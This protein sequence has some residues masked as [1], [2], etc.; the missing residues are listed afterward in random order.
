[1]KTLQV[2][3][4]VLPREIDQLERLCNTFKES[5]FF[6]ENQINDQVSLIK[7]TLNHLTLL[8]YV[9]YLRKTI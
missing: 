8:N 3:V 1:M 6:V 4:H 7:N 2:V 9:Y 5:Y